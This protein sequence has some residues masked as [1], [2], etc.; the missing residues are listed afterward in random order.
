MLCD[1][2][3]LA[4]P[5]MLHKSAEKKMFG[6]FLVFK[7]QSST[8]TKLRKYYYKVAQVLQSCARFIT[9]LRKHYKVAQ[10]LHFCAEQKSFIFDIITQNMDIIF[11]S[12]YNFLNDVKIKIIGAFNIKFFFH[13]H[14]LHVS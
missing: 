11:L 3:V 1:K 14:F 9:K 6:I 8:I 10:L 4:L 2:S 12:T 13:L 5:L 7:L